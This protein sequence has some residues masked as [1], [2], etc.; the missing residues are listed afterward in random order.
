M[1]AGAHRWLGRGSVH[2]CHEILREVLT[3]SCQQPLGAFG[4][5]SSR[6]MPESDHELGLCQTDINKNMEF[7]FLHRACCSSSTVKNH[8]TCWASHSA[9]F[10]KSINYV[11]L[12]TANMQFKYK[13]TA[14]NCFIFVVQ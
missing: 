10:E 14:T 1:H 12:R 13:N 5:P 4:H 3:E 11:L 6:R 8:F 7:I 9:N 2:V